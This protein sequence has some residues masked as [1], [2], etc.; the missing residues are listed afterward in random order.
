MY[1]NILHN[2]SEVTDVELEALNKRRL[3]EKQLILDRDLDEG[4]KNLWF[5]V[6]SAWLY[7]WKSFISNKSQPLIVNDYDLSKSL[8]ISEN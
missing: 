3:M 2:P 8:R 4:S 5:M 6:S 7:Q 1:K